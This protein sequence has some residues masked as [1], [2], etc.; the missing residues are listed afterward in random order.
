MSAAPFYTRVFDPLN[1]R[2]IG[3][4]PFFDCEF[5]LPLDE[6]GEFTGKLALEDIDPATIAHLKR[7]LNYET[8]WLFVYYGAMIPWHGRI[9]AAPW[10][11]ESG[12]LEVKAAHTRSWLDQVMVG[13]GR[14]IRHSWANIEQAQIVRNLVA[15]VATGS[16]GRLKIHADSAV[17]G[18]QRTLVVEPQSFGVVGDLIDTMATDTN[19]FDWDVLARDS[20]ADGMPEFYLGQWYP[21]RRSPGA[22]KFL[23]ADVGE[24]A[25]ILNDPGWPEDASARRSMVHALGDGEAPSMTTAVDYDPLLDN[26]QLLLT[27]K[28]TSYSGQGVTSASALAGLAH[29]ER[30]QLSKTLS[31]LTVAVGLD[32]PEYGSWQTGDRFRLQLRDEWLSTDLSAVRCVDH[33]VYFNQSDGNDL[34]SLELDIADNMAYSRTLA[35]GS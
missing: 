33:S 9:V 22:P 12:T 27:E 16:G 2:Y 3:E 8:A 14:N 25:N 1:R 17:T 21:E 19:G 35:G 30:V 4:F 20:A 15:L 31:T 26:N 28:T 24:H 7:S 34:V 13:R 11:R 32:D 18:V 29:A 5:N 23:L 6:A 10:S